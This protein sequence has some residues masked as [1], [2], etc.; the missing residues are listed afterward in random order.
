MSEAIILN[1][2][3]KS[4]NGRARK[5]L[6]VAGVVLVAGLFGPKLL[7]GGGALPPLPDSGVSPSTTLAAPP[8]MEADLAFS[9]KDPFRPLVAAPTDGAA[10]ATAAGSTAVPATSG[11]AVP[12]I[13][14]TPVAVT[15][16][17][18]VP[19]SD[20]VAPPPPPAPRPA[21]RFGLVAVRSLEDGVSSASVRV[22]G[23]VFDARVG[24]DFAG[25][26]RIVSLDTA[27]KCG[28]FLFGDQHF[29]LCEGEETMT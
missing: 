21:V 13:V 24:Q 22:D 23:A 19:E 3:A 11:A 12:E 28:E 26:Y 20:V 9:T 7:G 5:L 14:A 16:P 18:P 27:S 10:P 15:D 6:G 4:G 25:S 29:S 2:V 1:E 17:V 8:A